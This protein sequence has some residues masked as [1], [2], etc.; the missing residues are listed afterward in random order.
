MGEFVQQQFAAGFLVQLQIIGANPR[1]RQKLGHGALMDIG[2]L[3]HIHG[4]E[5]KAEGGD[6][7]AQILQPSVRQ[8]GAAIFPQRDGDDVQ[9]GGE[10]F[11]RGI[12]LRLVARRP[13]RAVAQQ[14]GAGRGHA[15]ITGD[16]R[17]AV[18]LVALM[19]GKSWQARRP[20][21]SA[22]RWW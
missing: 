8:V 6:T 13:G 5:M 21:S 18:R 1:H 22:P 14:G 10:F 19:R 17:Q 20:V 16:Q 7:L 11:R 4:G 9:I 2:I 15:R 3:A 12:G